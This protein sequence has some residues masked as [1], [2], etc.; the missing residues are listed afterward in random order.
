MFMN[1]TSD[2]LSVHH[3]AGPHKDPTFVTM[4]DAQ[5][6]RGDFGEIFMQQDLGLHLGFVRHYYHVEK[7][8]KVPLGKLHA[9][10]M[11]MYMADGNLSI[12]YEDSEEIILRDGYCYLLYLPKGRYRISL[13]KGKCSS[14][15][16]LLNESLL[17]RFGGAVD[18]LDTAA[19]LLAEDD[20]EAMQLQEL[21][22]NRRSKRLISALCKNK[23][24]GAL[25]QTEI[26][27]TMVE[28]LTEYLRQEGDLKK[29]K[30]T[31]YKID[32]IP[33][34]ILK[35]AEDLFLEPHGWETS[36]KAF[37]KS[38]F[39]AYYR[40]LDALKQRLKMNKHTFRARMRMEHACKLLEETQLSVLEVSQKLGYADPSSF[41]D[42]FTK[43]I[44]CS[45]KV[46]RRRLAARN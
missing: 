21:H 1:V 26:E 29:N 39:I 7:A 16:L 18:D 13:L 30:G 28:L 40:L 31:K 32:D 45:P 8:A 38:K 14:L 37:A 23:H 25:R 17:D 33:E 9:E 6:I 4:I 43:D 5:V 10:V 20:P 34:D 27:R 24:T 12:L 2:G 15:Q 35:E 44:G 36:L 42:R 46:Y 41:I 11:L 19:F 3:L 22:T